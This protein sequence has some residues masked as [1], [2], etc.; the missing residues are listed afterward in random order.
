M[1]CIALQ[2]LTCNVAMRPEA[3]ARNAARSVLDAL[4]RWR[5]GWTR[6]GI[7]PQPHDCGPDWDPADAGP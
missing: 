7:N 4:L 6:N 2:F 5:C 1:S 3:T